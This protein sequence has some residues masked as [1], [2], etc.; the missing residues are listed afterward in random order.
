MRTKGFIIFII[1]FT[2][3]YIVFFVVYDKLAFKKAKKDARHQVELLITIEQYNK[4]A[5]FYGIQP[6]ATIDMI[7]KVYDSVKNNKDCTI[8]TEAKNHN[9]N[10]LEFVAIV[11]YLEYL[12][13]IPK[14][15]ISIELDCMK[16]TSFVEQN[17]MQKYNTYFQNKTPL[18]DIVNAMGKNAITDLTAMNSNFLMPGVRYVNSNLYYVGDYL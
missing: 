16:K 12:G 6:V 4:F 1:I 13:L 17:M 10:N 18:S 3:A 5:S 15:M 8:S 7:L 14:K 9:L 11:L 2:I